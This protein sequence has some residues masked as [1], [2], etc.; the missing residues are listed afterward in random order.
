MSRR[1]GAAGTETDSGPLV[2]VVEDDPG[3][4]EL[5]AY[6]LNDAGYRT[7]VARSGTEPTGNG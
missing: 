5:L 6:Q 2:L 7:R 1:F 3:S 4:A